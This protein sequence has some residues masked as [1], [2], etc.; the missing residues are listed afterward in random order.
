[1]IVPL[2]VGKKAVRFG[3]KRYGVPGAIVAGGF[4]VVGYVAVRRAIEA[5]KESDR[6]NEAVDVEALENAVDAEGLAAVAD[7][8]TLEQAVDPEGVRSA[9]AN[10][11]R[12]DTSDEV[13][14]AIEDAQDEPDSGTSDDA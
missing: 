11:G 2:A 14:V 6:I 12:S 3:Y 9:V 13:D 1:M 4:V 8:E 7:P 5:A 10:E